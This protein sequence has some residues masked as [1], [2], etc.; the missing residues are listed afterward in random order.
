M[1]S[2]FLSSFMTIRKFLWDIE[3]FGSALNE[4][5]PNGRPA[6]HIEISG[7]AF[8]SFYLTMSE[9]RPDD[10]PATILSTGDIQI[11]FSEVSVCVSKRKDL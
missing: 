2:A 7:S 8:D 11:N 5:T 4:H 6:I 3:E 1:S 10:I 9:Y